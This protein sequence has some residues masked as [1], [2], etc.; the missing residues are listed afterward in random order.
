VALHD[1]AISA[2]RGIIAQIAPALS[3]TERKHPDSRHNT[4]QR[5]KN[6]G[7]GQGKRPRPGVRLNE[8]RAVGSV[9]RHEGLR[10]RKVRAR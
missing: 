9:G 8:G 2:R 5:G 1:V 7:H 6:N 3:I 4:E 10:G